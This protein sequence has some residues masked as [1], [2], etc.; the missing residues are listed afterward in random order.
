MVIGS[1]VASG[2]LLAY[3]RV[4][5]ALLENLRSISE[6][7]IVMILPINVL[8]LILGTFMDMSPLIVITPPIFRPVATAYGL[9][10]VQFGVIL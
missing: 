7:P 9:D 4:P 3:L 5:T 1:A 6:N 8:L 2:W 10:P